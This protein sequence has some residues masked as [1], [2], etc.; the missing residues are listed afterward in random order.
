[1]DDDGEPVRIDKAFSSETVA[2]A[3]L[4]LPDTS[5]PERHG[6]LSMLDRPVSEYDGP[7]DSVRIPVLPKGSG[8]G[9]SRP[10]AWPSGLRPTSTCC[11][12]IT[13]PR[14]SRLVDT[15]TYPLNALT[16]RPMAMYHSRDSQ[17]AWLRQIHSHSYLFVKPTI[18]AAN[19]FD[20]GDWIWVESPHGKVRC[21]C[22]FSEAVEP[23]TVWTWNGIGKASGTWGLHPGRT[24]H[25][26]AS[27]KQWNTSGRAGPL[28][29]KNPDDA[30]RTG[31]F[32]NRVSFFVSGQR[33]DITVTGPRRPSR[34]FRKANRVP[35]SN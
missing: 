28:A 23:G 19:G 27:C 22:R 33:P 25:A 10:D 9:G 34:G 5:Y 15:Q 13:S 31:T 3:D 30:A 4:V 11:P 35:A 26:R 2:F 6:A 21:L 8:R 1:V 12:S 14:E 29:D 16:Q 24:S 18:G 17:N 7:V 32:L 20:D